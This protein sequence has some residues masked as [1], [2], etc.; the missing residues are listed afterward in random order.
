MFLI[1]ALAAITAL[2]I[3][4]Y[5]KFKGLR[6]E[7][8]AAAPDLKKVRFVCLNGHYVYC[9]VIWAVIS[10]LVSYIVVEAIWAKFAVLVAL[11]FVCSMVID[12]FYQKNLNAKTHLE[13]ILKGIMAA[14]ALIGILVTILIALSIFFEA[15]QFF[16][17]VAISDFLFGL[18]WNPQMVVDGGHG[19]FGMVPVIL[20]T[21]LIAMIAML[22]SIP[23]GVMA[24][25]F[26]G[27]Y[28]KSSLRD[29]LKP[30]LEILAGVPTVVYGYFAVTVMAPF[31]KGSFALIGV[32]IAAE[33]ALAAGFVMGVMIIPFILSLSDDALNSVPRYLKDG[34]LALG[35]TKSEMISKVALPYAMPSII[36]AV[37]LAFSRAIGET[38]I[39]VMAAGLVANL[40]LNPL[41]SVTTATAQIVTLL[42]GDQEFDSAKTL[43]A[44]ALALVLFVVTF[45][46]NIVA[47][48]VMKRYK[49]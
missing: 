14:T 1:T 32:N 41:D 23:L 40:T 11:L 33:S 38:M 13:S 31:F 30:V 21:L 46:F 6:Q 19:V 16:E 15:S 36:G 26:L 49:R 28:A 25:I 43:A 44:F 48:R 18:E 20:G 2:S 5:L 10:A 37:I 12:Y 24:A 3:R 39:V 17:K 42:V 22:V 29:I 47:L 7:L 9:F 4:L 34:A 35:S 45:T 8:I 27:F